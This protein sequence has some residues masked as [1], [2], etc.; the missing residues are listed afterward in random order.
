M[1]MIFQELKSE[2]R[3]LSPVF[4]LNY[5]DYSQS[6]GCCVIGWWVGGAAVGGFNKTL[7]CQYLK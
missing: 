1:A 7:I 2:E 4:C 6:V 3:V 5:F